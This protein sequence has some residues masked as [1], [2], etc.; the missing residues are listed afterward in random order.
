M[1]EKLLFITK[2]Y[3]SD[4]ETAVGLLTMRVSKSDVD[5]WEK[6]RRILSFVHCTLKEKRCF[7]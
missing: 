7:G 2:M 6:L 3:N 5:D 1:M 4:L